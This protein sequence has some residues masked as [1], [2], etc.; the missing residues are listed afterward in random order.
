MI[1]LIATIIILAVV[2]GLKE[3]ELEIEKKKL[4]ILEKM[5]RKMGA[6]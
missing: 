1:I 4:A 6:K 3:K 5:L 2:T